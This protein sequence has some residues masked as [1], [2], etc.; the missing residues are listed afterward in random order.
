[1]LKY[2]DKV[3]V[4]SGFYEGMEGLIFRKEVFTNELFSFFR[5]SDTIKEYVTYTIYSKDL[6][7]K[8]ILIDWFKESDLELIK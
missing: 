4:K 5:S 3:R 1:M 2:N 6:R 8:E 7:G